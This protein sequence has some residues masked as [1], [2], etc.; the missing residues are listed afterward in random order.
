MIGTP[1]HRYPRHH[2]LLRSVRSDWRSCHSKV[3]RQG[4]F[5][6]GPVR[7]AQP[8]MRCLRGNLVVRIF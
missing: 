6:I 5:E 8:Q 4:C 3:E 1:N 2:R 7:L